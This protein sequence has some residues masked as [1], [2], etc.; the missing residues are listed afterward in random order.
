MIAFTAPALRNLIGAVAALL[1]G[2]TMLAAAAA[3]ALVPG[4]TSN[5]VAVA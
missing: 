3:P 2:G 4:Q 5:I 1:I